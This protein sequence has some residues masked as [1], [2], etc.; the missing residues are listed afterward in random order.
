MA[1][2]K[3]KEPTH[4]FE[5]NVSKLSLSQEKYVD[6]MISFISENLKVNDVSKDGNHISVTLPES[7]TKRMF[8]LRLNRFLYQ[9]GLKSD[10]RLISMLNEGKQGY[11]FMD[12]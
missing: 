3:K 7:I 2:K 1:R 8:K 11:M 6:Q 9:S 4:V 10:F 12:R 5:V